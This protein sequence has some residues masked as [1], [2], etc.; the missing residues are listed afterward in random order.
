MST[1]ANAPRDKRHLT[2]A[3]V[4][5]PVSAHIYTRAGWLD[6]TFPVPPIHSFGDWL[7]HGGEFLKLIDVKLPAA[8]HT[9][10]FFAL[11]RHAVVLVVPKGPLDRPERNRYLVQS[12]KPHKVTVLLR[13]G[14]VEGTVDVLSDVRVSDFLASWPRFI[15]IHDAVVAF[16]DHG[17]PSPLRPPIPLLFVNGPQV[18]GFVEID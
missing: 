9:I 2:E 10:P 18:I 17:T 3:D 13:S 8:S 6:G 12:T 11:Q 1:E 14:V 15:P 4:R 7:D 16:H 5:R